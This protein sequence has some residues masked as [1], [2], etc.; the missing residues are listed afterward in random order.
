[1]KTLTG[2][3]GNIIFFNLSKD[4]FILFFLPNTTCTCDV[5]VNTCPGLE[6][7]RIKFKYPILLKLI[8]I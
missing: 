1:M 5:F 3:Q 8:S 2:M 6:R 7:T 4:H